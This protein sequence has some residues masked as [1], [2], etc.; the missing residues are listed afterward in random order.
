MDIS[1][2]RFV[3]FTTFDRA[4]QI[5]AAGKLMMRPPYEKFGGDLVYAVSAIWGDS[6]IGTQTTHIKGKNIVA[7]VFQTSTKPKYGFVEEVVWD[8]DV[9]LRNPKVVTKSKGLSLIKGAN[10]VTGDDMV[11]YASSGS[12]DS[13]ERVVLMD[14]LQ[15]IEKQAAK[16][17]NKKEVPSQEGGT[18]TVY[19]Y[20]EG[21]VQHRHTEKAKKVEKLRK[22]IGSLRT[23]YGKDLTNSDAKTRLTAL[24][25]ALIDQTCERP[26]NEESVKERGH[27]GIS[28]L[29]ARHV[30]FEG[31]KAVLSYTGKSGVKHTK[32]VTDAKTVSALKKACKGKKGED[33]V[34]CD[35]D[36]CNVDASD[37]NT[38]LQPFDVTAKDI[39]GMRANEE[40][41]T[42]LKEERKKGPAL[43]RD[44]KEKDEILKKEFDAA[45]KATAKVV[46]HEEATLKGQYLVPK[47]ES[48]YMHDGT[49]I[50]KLY[51]KSA[52]SGWK[53]APGKQNPRAV[54]SFSKWII[55]FDH[56]T[57]AD[58]EWTSKGQLKPGHMVRK[59]M[60][61]SS[62]S[63]A[64]AVIQSEVLDYI[65]AYKGQSFEKAIRGWQPIATK[66]A[67]KY[68]HINFT[69]PESVANAAAKGLEYRQKAS[70]SNKGG[71]TPSQAAQEGIGSGVQRAVNLKN[72]N[73]LTP[74]TIKKMVGF[75][76]RHE[77][78]KGVKPENK[79]EPWNDKG[80]VAWLLWGGDPGRAFANKVK[81]QMDAADAKQASRV[82]GRFIEAGENEPTDPGLWAKVVS[83][84]K[85]ETKSLSHNGETVNG[86]NEGKGFQ[87][88][89]SA[90][91]NGW[92]SKVY[93][94]LGGGWKK[95]SHL[96]FDK[97]YKKAAGNHTL[98]KLPYAYDALEPWISQETV[99]LHHDKHHQSYVD[100]LNEAEGALAQAKKTGDFDTIRKI[101][102]DI[103]FNWGGHYLHTAYWESLGTGVEASEGLKSEVDKAFGS[104]D[105][106]KDLFL[107]T[108]T[109]VQGSGWAVL[110]WNPDTGMQIAGIKNHEQRVL[111]GS[112]VLLPLDVWEHAY[113][114]DT[115]NDRAAH[116]EKVFD[117]CINWSKVEDR[118]TS[119][120]G[121]TARGKA[122]KDV[123]HGGLDE[124]FSGHGGAKGKGENATWGDW[125]SISPVTK[126]LPSG[127]KVE[128]GD[129]VGDCGISDS[130][131]WKEETKGGKNPL[132]CMPRQKAYDMDKS[133]R[134]DK[135]QA[136]QKAEKAS[137][138][139]KKPT[140]TETFSKKSSAGHYK[141]MSEMSAKQRENFEA[142]VPEWLDKE[143][144]Y[145]APPDTQDTMEELRYLIGLVPLREKYNDFIVKAD[146]DFLSQFKE[147]CES[148]G[149][150]FDEEE[151]RGILKDGSSVIQK[152]KWRYNRIRPY[153]FAKKH[154]IDFES[155]DTES[156]HSP[157]YPSGHTL[158]SRLIAS[159]LAETS[160]QHRKAF[161]DLA[162]NISWSRAL[163]G[164][165][166]PSDLIYSKDLFRHIKNEKMPSH[167]RVASRS[168]EAATDGESLAL[169]KWLSEATRRMGVDKHVYV[170][171]GAVRNFVLKQPI[172]DIDMVVD[173]LALRG[174]RD[175]EWVAKGI[176]KQIPTNTKVVTDSLMVTK[177]HIQGSWNLDGYEM[178]GEDIEIVNARKE[179]YAQDDE[180]NY[181]G[182]KPIR[183]E[184]TTLEDDVTRREF[185]FNT[186]MWR[187]SDL[188]S[189][190]DKA[191]IID[192]TGCGLDD[193][194]NLEM[195]CPR[196][197]DQTFKEDPTRII[198]TIKFAFKYGFK[199]PSD[200]A[201]AAKRQAKG[202]KRIPSKTETVLKTI[203]LDNPQYKKAFNV[204]DKLG[205]IDVLK[206]MMQENPKTF[207]S[208]M[209]NNAKSKGFAYMFDLMDIGLPVGKQVNFLEK[210]ELK[211]FREI[212]VGLSQDDS[213][214]LLEGL[215]NP[216]N[217][218]KDDRFFNEMATQLG[219]SKKERGKL[220]KLLSTLNREM[221]LKNPS[222]MNK[223]TVLKEMLRKALLRNFRMASTV[224]LRHADTEA[225]LNPNLGWPGGP[226][227]V[228]QRIENEVR[229]P[230]LK[231][232]LQ[233]KVEDGDKLTNPEA[234]KIYSI[235]K[236]RGSKVK[237]L[238]QMAITP[239]AQYRM[240]QRGITVNDLRQTLN[241]F[242]RAF[243]DSKSQNGWEFQKWSED[244]AYGKQIRWEDPKHARMVT[245]FQAD[246]RGKVIIITT[247]WE[248]MKD[249]QPKG[250]CDVRVAMRHL[251]E[252][253]K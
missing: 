134:A 41:K 46:G 222:L 189:G 36:D 80:H 232:N 101:N 140:N 180:G 94:D 54:K 251:M 48:S 186:L 162:D 112:V 25:V 174:N 53:K 150:P 217:L 113:Y 33:P 191:E 30:S 205:V 124:W 40:M 169:M 199:L 106:F 243:Y 218:Y 219:V 193:L 122:K 18:T 79:G 35:G 241:N 158:Q 31:S 197:P 215:K 248:G 27:F 105:V 171:G 71:L 185:T 42:R 131:D 58:Y 13:N 250:T 214:R 253:N 119:S 148:L 21:Q 170:V 32:D 152:L 135:A 155:M 194:N 141:P 78:N 51:E 16:F 62:E 196:S 85:G 245:V 4:K 184:P 29:Q 108:A 91:A 201:A 82:A 182:H 146:K 69:P 183:V 204:M 90:Y 59:V 14:M 37:L 81:K 247:Y 160:P 11:K 24:G 47:L 111:W 127:K 224:A 20:T 117:N 252:T 172:K 246:G 227:H 50:D 167:I 145:V 87:K 75:F 72:R 6:V 143:Y 103:A 84:A 239:H 163:G 136:K 3:H 216:G 67:S 181:L 77:K 60:E 57:K 95:K 100:G 144:P 210:N 73:N 209:Q 102:E 173:S 177:I 202:L 229:N 129:I 22:S 96:T 5:I 208:F 125:V 63:Q 34:L 238:Q 114:I 234:N 61:F 56:P 88:Y 17:Q 221:V 164:I 83:L 151:C 92:A 44:R 220:N 7:I 97:T 153:Q 132:K 128:R 223:P 206:E 156:G 240:D 38:Y 179:E 213:T 137:P 107:N 244:M 159:H 211:R 28:T 118:M 10:S 68:D 168:L 93:G 126:T 178:D 165:H 231:E 207:G 188:A 192:I 116:F 23:Q 147:L 154:G 99:K 65:V 110:T 176:A 161:M 104:W 64:A 2:D 195:K 52:A 109:S 130:A 200:V 225:D 249:P 70:P 242:G 43:P 236:E 115:K 228:V 74:E 120:V 198:R 157:A 15:G 230:R 86:P 89:P 49:V 175:A 212:T 235:Q 233:D 19:E 142:K 166:W 39:R 149:A 45:L 66:Q 1:K 8:R 12:L 133:E 237:F 203:V 98:P 121:K 76:S 123:G 226:C 139:S 138:N 190:P 187:L 9:V 55:Q 26:G